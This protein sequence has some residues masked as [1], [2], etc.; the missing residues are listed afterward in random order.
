MLGVAGC[1]YIVV[2]GGLDGFS[3]LKEPFKE[4]IKEALKESGFR[5]SHSRKGRQGSTFRAEGFG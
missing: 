4:P 3:A 1:C 5:R 2:L